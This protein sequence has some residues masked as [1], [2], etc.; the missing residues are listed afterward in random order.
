MQKL[1]RTALLSFSLLLAAC[2]GATEDLATIVQTEA[3]A[4]LNAE[5][6]AVQAEM[7]LQ[8]SQAQNAILQATIDAQ[9]SEAAAPTS[10]PAD[11][12]TPLPEP[13]ATRSI[14][15]NTAAPTRPPGVA[16]RFEATF[17]CNGTRMAFFSVRNTGPE[18]YQSARVS[19]ADASSDTELGR[20]DGNNEFL[21]NSTACSG[22]QATL[23]PGETKYLSVKIGAL[24][25]NTQVIA[26]IVVCTEK[27]YGGNCLSHGVHFTP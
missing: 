12:S 1:T 19:A 20:S 3:M 2:S 5:A 7:A 18:T 11:T 16:V 13:T 9:A 6:V 22:Y 14:P 17:T 26:R 24:P 4:T 23:G 21:P 15:T 8:T 25:P 27:G 10:P